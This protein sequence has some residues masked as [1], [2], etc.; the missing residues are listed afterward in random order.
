MLRVFVCLFAVC[1][2]S[3]DT[4][5][6]QSMNAQDLQLHV[7]TG[8]PAEMGAALGKAQEGKIRMLLAIFRLR[9][10]PN[11]GPRTA[12]IRLHHREEI[13]AQAQ[14]TGVSADHLMTAHLI[15][16]PQCSAV[17]VPPAENR[18]L[19]IGRNMDFAPEGLLG[20]ATCVHVWRAPGLHAVASVGFPGLSGVVSG[21]NDAGVTACILLNKQQEDPLKT[22]GEPIILR[23][24]ACLEKADDLAAAIAV[25][26]ASAP[27]SG[28][29]VVF[30][31]AKNA[32]L[33]WWTPTGMRRIDL[34]QDAVMSVDNQPRDENGLGTG[35]RAKTLLGHVSMNSTV[36]EIQS[37][38]TSVY[39]KRLN[40]Q[41]MVFEPEHRSLLL[42]RGSTMRA[43]CL[44]PWVSVQLR[45]MLEGKAPLESEVLPLPAVKPLPHYTDR[46]K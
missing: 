16:E 41:V 27:G 20:Q 25:F 44:N 30:A 9:P 2:Y 6:L 17:I 11:P 38:M 10:H 40:A 12:L 32:A 37:A 5:V 31:D 18:P 24:R 35:I 36:E 45:G 39:L 42:A 3:Q 23:I 15:T 33:C 4:P 7:A 26:Q 8:T 46:K 43:A 22:P 28:H 13:L 1:L 29:Y 19:R 34:K 14:A 21:M